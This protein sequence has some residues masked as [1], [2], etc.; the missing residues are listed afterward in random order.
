[1]IDRSSVGESSAFQS[2]T[3]RARIDAAFETTALEVESGRLSLDQAKARM[4]ALGLRIVDEIY[5]P[6]PAPSEIGPA[7]RAATLDPL[8]AWNALPADVHQRIGAAAV[9]AAV[10]SLGLSIA[11]EHADPVAHRPHHVAYSEALSLIYEL[12]AINVLDG[13]NETLPP[14]PDLRP[15]GIAQCR[16]CGCTNDFACDGGCHWVRSDLCSACAEAGRI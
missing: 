14:R 7:A 11:I 2:D 4:R 3:L 15:L 6:D 5:R 8:A 16:V 12:V 13:D 10:A 1:M 9:A